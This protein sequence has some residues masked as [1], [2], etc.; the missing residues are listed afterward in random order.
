M[1]GEGVWS[2]R[3]SILLGCH[4]KNTISCQEVEPEEDLDEQIRMENLKKLSMGKVRITKTIFL[5]FH[6][7]FTVAQK[8]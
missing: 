6:Q 4:L 3:E 5:C 2:N 8:T 1:G 7:S